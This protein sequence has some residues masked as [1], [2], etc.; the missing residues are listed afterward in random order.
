MNHQEELA[1]LLL[2]DRRIQEQ[3]DQWERD[4]NQIPYKFGWF[5]WSMVLAVVAYIGLMVSIS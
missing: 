5:E 3:C 1:R 2:Q 4:R